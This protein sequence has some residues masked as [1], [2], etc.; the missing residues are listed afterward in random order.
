MIIKNPTNDNRFLVLLSGKPSAGV[1]AIGDDVSGAVIE[2]KFIGQI[3]NVT[4]AVGRDATLTCQVDSL[5]TYR[6]RATFVNTYNDE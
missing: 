1:K 3:Q 4:V 5:G 6:V 2:P